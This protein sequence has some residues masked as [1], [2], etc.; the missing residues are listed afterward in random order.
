MCSRLQAQFLPAWQRRRTFALAHLLYSAIGLV[1]LLPLLGVM[2]RVLLSWSGSDVLTDEEILRFALSGPGAIAAILMGALLLFVSVFEQACMMTLAASQHDDK[3]G[4]ILSALSHNL[5]RAPR[6]F[7]FSLCLVLR[8]ALI[9]L[10]FIA[11]AAIA[12]LALLTEYDINFYLYQKPT[13]FW[14]ALAI[15]AALLAGL[16]PLLLGKLLDWSMALPLILFSN[17]SA[18]ASFVLSQQMIS[19]HRQPLL[20]QLALWASTLVLLS[21]LAALGLRLLGDLTLALAAD[22]LQG[23]VLLLGGLAG[24]SLLYSFLLTALASSSFASTLIQCF[25]RLDPDW[26]NDHAHIASQALRPATK[27]PLSLRGA[28]LA[29][30]IAVPISAG[31]GL[32][33]LA[34]SQFDDRIEVI[35]HRGAAGSAPENTLAAMRQAMADGADWLEI[36]VQETRDGAVI[37]MHDSDFMKLSGIDLKVWDG[38]LAQIQ[39]LDVG[40]WF[41][42]EFVGES[43]PTLEQVLLAARG[44]T[45]VLIELKYYGHDQQLEQRVIDIVERL[46]MVEQ[47]QIMSLNYAGLE[48]IR[49]LRPDWPIGLLVAQST[50]DL[51]QRDVDFLA[52]NQ[53]IANRA[54]VQRAKAAGKPLYVWT[55]ND[56]VS[57]SRLSSLGVDGL[58]TDEPALARQVLQQRAQLTQSERL[59]LHTA[60]LL[61]QPLPQSHYR[62]NSP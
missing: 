39:A 53:A 36:D 27:P 34:Q 9:I 22:T 57:I 10:P 45:K 61:G 54:L 28:L 26:T 11:V 4:Q 52:V 16:I 62:D 58:I 2:G 60:L 40:R 59:L 46:E 3:P 17:T 55:V 41:G 48:K 35:A 5:K 56:A 31:I 21:T 51:T 15:L 49:A 29:V 6:L 47:I 8:L 19:G 25:K 50:G 43:V 18:K 24:L 1:V 42:P 14:W 7:E 13:A 33:L 20:G 12:G 44:Q 37:V 38:T 30:A 23:L 32:W